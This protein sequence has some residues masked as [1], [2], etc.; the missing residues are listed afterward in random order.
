MQQ[1]GSALSEPRDLP[2]NLEDIELMWNFAKRTS[3]SMAPT[4]PGT[5]AESDVWTD[6]IPDLA[7]K[8]EFLMH[9][10]LALSALHL[11]YLRPEQKERWRN[12]RDRHIERGLALYRVAINSVNK[13]TCHACWLFSIVLALTE[14]PGKTLSLSSMQSGVGFVNLLR[15]GIALHVPFIEELNNGPVR[16]LFEG[17]KARER[18]SERCLPKDEEAL[19]KIS[20]YWSPLTS[21]YTRDQGRMFDENL[22][23]LKEVFAL[24]ASQSVIPPVS[25]ALA[26]A[27]TLAEE[28][29]RLIAVSDTGALILLAHFCVLLNRVTDTWWI[30]GE[31][32]P[33]LISI[34]E[35]LGPENEKWIRYPLEE[36]GI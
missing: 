21:D 32:V 24:Q 12:A 36:V 4:A 22:K 1:D 30:E 29:T 6:I 27:S 34:R 2:L 17:W 23:I 9:G 18:E 3:H 26:W 15:A 19:N 35:V 11:A 25:C 33:L 13:E 7:L 10:V 16:G 28:Y 20:R 5:E 8:Y 31:A 14:K